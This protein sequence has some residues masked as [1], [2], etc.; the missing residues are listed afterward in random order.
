ME[1]R[2]N[3]VPHSVR[4]LFANRVGIARSAIRGRALSP[5]PEPNP[6][7]WPGSPHSKQPIPL[8]AVRQTN[9]FCKP[10]FSHI[11]NS[12][13]RKYATAHPCALNH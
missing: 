2:R 3:R 7:G 6:G 12:V 4:P 11:S 13:L 5:V 10:A 8:Q 1:R 9:S